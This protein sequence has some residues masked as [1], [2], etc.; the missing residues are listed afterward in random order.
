VPLVLV[1]QLLLPTYL[2]VV[3]AAAEVAFSKSQVVVAVG[4]GALENSPSL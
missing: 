4:L 2:S 1:G 3:A